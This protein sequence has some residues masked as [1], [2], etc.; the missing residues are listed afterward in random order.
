MLTWL[1]SLFGGKPEPAPVDPER[2][3]TLAVIEAYRQF[4]AGKPSV[5]QETGELP[6][7]KTEISKA[8]R[9]ELT[10]ALHAR[11]WE[12]Y[13]RLKADSIMLTNFQDLAACK[14]RNQAPET[15]MI[16]EV[17]LLMTE[18]DDMAMRLGQPADAAA[19]GTGG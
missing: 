17:R 6:H 18:L 7:P 8:L 16:S 1:K 11:D 12:R 10:D 2:L 3:N 9:S 4:I 5:V 15:V 14:L 13:D 19:P